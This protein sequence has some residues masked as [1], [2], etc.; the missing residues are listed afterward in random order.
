MWKPAALLIFIIIVGTVGYVFIEDMSFLDSLYMTTI[1]IFT[2]GFREV[3][4]LSPIG[5]FFTIL[6][7]IIFHI[8]NSIEYSC[9]KSLTERRI[10]SDKCLIKFLFSMQ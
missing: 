4:P 6:I 9:L 10:K 2:V 3:K 1:T 5:Q 7:I 8:S